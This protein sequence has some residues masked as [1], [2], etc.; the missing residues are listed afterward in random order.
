MK[1]LCSTLTKDCLGH[2]NFLF[3][4]FTGAEQDTI[5]KKQINKTTMEINIF[6]ILF[7]IL[8]VIRDI[9][10]NIDKRMIA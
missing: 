5:K 6:L 4:C 2:L 7:G 1:I 9:Y 10:K 3:T 8:L